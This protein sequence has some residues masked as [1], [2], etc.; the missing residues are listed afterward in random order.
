MTDGKFFMILA[1]VILTVVAAIND[2][3]YAGLGLLGLAVVSGVVRECRRFLR[4]LRD[5]G[6]EAPKREEW[7]GAIR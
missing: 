7:P 6:K 1:I 5:A 4:K 2:S 3:L